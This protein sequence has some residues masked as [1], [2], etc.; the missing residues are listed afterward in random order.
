MS[1]ENASARH[2]FPKDMSY[3]QSRHASGASGAQ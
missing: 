3:V 1:V 2:L